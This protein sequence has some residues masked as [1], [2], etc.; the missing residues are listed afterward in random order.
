MMLTLDSPP[1]SRVGT[2]H[3][4]EVQQHVFLT[5]LSQGQKRYQYL[6]KELVSNHFFSPMNACSFGTDSD[7]PCRPD[8]PLGS[9][10]CW[11]HR[12]AA[13]AVKGIEPQAATLTR[14]QVPSEPHFCL[15][16][17]K[18]ILTGASRNS[19]SCQHYLSCDGAISVQGHHH[20]AIPV[21][22]SSQQSI[23]FVFCACLLPV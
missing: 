8:I 17:S 11:Q 12:F 6:Q 23:P 9:L 19:A 22:I 15:S 13:V 5:K 4:E 20:G 16:Q 3:H 14:P 2:H 1:G 7:N 10:V 18:E 21:L